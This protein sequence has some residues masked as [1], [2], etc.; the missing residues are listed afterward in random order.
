MCSL[1]PYRTG[2]Y[3]IEIRR[4]DAAQ[5]RAYRLLKLWYVSSKQYA[6]RSVGRSAVCSTP[7]DSVGVFERSS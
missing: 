6:A 4:P 2:G 3:E 5:S 7:P 1:G